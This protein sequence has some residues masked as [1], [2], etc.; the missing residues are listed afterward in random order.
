MFLKHCY[1]CGDPSGLH[2][3]LSLQARDLQIEDFRQQTG[4]KVSFKKQL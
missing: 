4:I 3:A 2:T 1:V